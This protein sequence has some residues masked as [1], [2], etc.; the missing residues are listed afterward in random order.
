MQLHR[1]ASGDSLALW[2]YRGAL[3]L[4]AVHLPRTSGALPACVF[5]R[6]LEGAVAL[7]PCGPSTR[8]GNGLLHPVFLVAGCQ[9]PVSAHRCLFFCSEAAVPVI[10]LSG[11][12]GDLR[13]RKDCYMTEIEHAVIERD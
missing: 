11:K 13:E 9:F 12:D 7:S 10:V 1:T 4:P 2:S 3:T 6:N 5:Y 8:E